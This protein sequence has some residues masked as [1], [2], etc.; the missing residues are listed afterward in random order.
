MMVFQ[1][2]TLCRL[3]NLPASTLSTTPHVLHTRTFLT[4][5]P[6]HKL[7]AAPSP[8]AIISSEEHK[9]RE[10]SRKLEQARK[11]FQFVTKEV[12]W[13]VAKA[14]VAVADHDDEHVDIDSDNAKEAKALQEKDTRQLRR[15]EGLEGRA[16]DRYLDDDDWENEAGRR[17]SIQRFS[18]TSTQIS[19]GGGSSSGG[20]FNGWSRK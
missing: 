1:G 5:P 7:R 4:L 10:R 9:E 12:D 14:Y 20:I 13:R 19:G 16:V 2:R 15:G 6:S 17:V 3:N 11:R 18:G 8:E